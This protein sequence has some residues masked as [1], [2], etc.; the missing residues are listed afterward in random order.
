M[1]RLTLILKTG[2]QFAGKFRPAIL[3]YTA[4]FMLAQATALLEPYVLGLMLN[5]V[6]DDITRG[7][8]GNA[9][10]LHDVIYYMSIFVGLKVIFWSIHGPTRLWERYVAFEITYAYKAHMFK[11][12]T[13]LPLKWQREHHSGESIDKINRAYN[14]LSDFFQGTFDI[15]YMICRL[16]GT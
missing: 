14:A 7:A 13:E 9:Q 8:A 11:T 2:W 1:D 15:N 10:L 6:Q 12:V 16:I 5:A 4:L 3:G